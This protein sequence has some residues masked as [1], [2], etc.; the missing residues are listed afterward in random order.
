MSFERSL[1]SDQLEFD[2]GLSNN[3]QRILSLTTFPRDQLNTKEVYLSWQ[4]TY[5][6]SKTTCNIRE[7]FFL[8]KCLENLLLAKYLISVA[9]DLRKFINTLFVYSQKGQLPKC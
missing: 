2:Y 7:K 1:N 4:N 9:A 5:P 6:N 8:S 3:L